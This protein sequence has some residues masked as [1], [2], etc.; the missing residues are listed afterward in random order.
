MYP[1]LTDKSITTEVY[2]VSVNSVK[3]I[4]LEGMNLTA[5]DL[6]PAEKLRKFGFSLVCCSFGS[7]KLTKAGL[8]IYM[9]FLQK[10]KIQIYW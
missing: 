7:E 5:A 9:M 4:P 1:D 10:K 6:A 2:Q 3:W 8:C